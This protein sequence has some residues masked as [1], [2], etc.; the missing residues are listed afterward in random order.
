MTQPALN[1]SIPWDAD[2]LD[3][4]LTAMLALAGGDDSGA[5]SG[6]LAELER[7]ARETGDPDQV[8][9]FAAALVRAWQ[10]DRAVAVLDRLVAG[11]PGY[12]PA[13]IDLA[14][15]EVAAGLADDALR[16][17][18][19]A[20][21]G[22]GGTERSD[23]LLEQRIAEL[24]EWLRWRDDQYRWLRLQA[25]ALRE[26]LANGPAD[27]TD[28]AALARSLLALGQASD[29]D[30]EVM[31]AIAVL[32]AAVQRYGDDVP[33]LELL[34]AARLRHG[35][36]GERWHDML[37]TL[38]R[39]APHSKILEVVGQIE[40]AETAT[41][42]DGRSELVQAVIDRAWNGDP[43]A[44]VELRRLYQ[45]N[46]RDP[47]CTNGLMFAEILQGDR[48]VALALADRLAALP[49][50][51][52]GHHFNLAQVYW[53]TG[54]RPDAEHHLELAVAT[55]ADDEE[56]HDVLQLRERL[57]DEESAGRD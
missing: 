20:A 22:S 30:A 39:L 7:R 51:K 31:E 5:A 41:L 13:R 17:L 4:G 44:M 52:H 38:E 46:P 11:S 1:W 47:H 25:G 23:G 16:Q 21:A 42:T 37:R 56:R 33:T 50:L 32:E 34:I 53:R 24:R 12:L 29:T 45:R 27:V 10:T 55:A 2:S 18:L 9:L 49:D 40:S 14:T 43:A 54:R 19:D 6:V 28:H 26:R 57:L 48:N 8:R 36:T 3:S 35:E 15:A